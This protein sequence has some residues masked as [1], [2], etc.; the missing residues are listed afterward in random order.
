[1][2]ILY[3]SQV[4]K[5][6]KVQDENQELK[7]AI[8]MVGDQ[9]IAL[10]KQVLLNCDWKSTQFCMTS[11]RFNHQFSSVAQSYPTL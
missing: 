6:E 7:T 1:M 4:Q 3:G 2:L 9:V 10:Q 11:L 8:Q 5:D